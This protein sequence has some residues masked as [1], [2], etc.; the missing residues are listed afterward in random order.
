MNRSDEIKEVSGIL[1]VNMCM[2]EHRMTTLRQ[3]E[4]R[5]VKITCI[6]IS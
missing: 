6:T 5:D 2:R 3:D 4:V 1:K